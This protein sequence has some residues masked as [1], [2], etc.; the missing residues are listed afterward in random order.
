MKENGN[1]LLLGILG[2]VV[3]LVIFNLLFYR[4]KYEEDAGKEKYNFNKE[5]LDLIR[6]TKQQDLL[7]NT[8]MGIVSN[9]SRVKR[10]FV[11]PENEILTHALHCCRCFPDYEDRQQRIQG[12]IYPFWK[13]KRVS[14]YIE[15]MYIKKLR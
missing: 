10:E 4:K 13:K 7:C 2:G 12:I 3:V 1:A 8:A 6:N 11:L 14:N 5:H 15:Q 9:S